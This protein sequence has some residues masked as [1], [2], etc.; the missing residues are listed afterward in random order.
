MALRQAKCA[1]FFTFLCDA[2]IEK[3]ASRFFG[4]R[5]F[6]FIPY[7]AQSVTIV[8]NISAFFSISA[9]EPMHSFTPCSA[10]LSTSPHSLHILRR[11]GLHDVHLFFRLAERVRAL[12]HVV[13]RRPR[14]R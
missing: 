1:K 10:S 5:V 6:D 7:S 13:D 2:A 12:Q 14:R 8:S 11:E 4:K 9:A 3:H